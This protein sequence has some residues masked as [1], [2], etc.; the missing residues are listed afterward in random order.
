MEAQ[1][2]CAGALL[3][4]G[5]TKAREPLFLQQPSAHS[6][7]LLWPEGY[8]TEQSRRC[9]GEFMRTWKLTPE[10][11]Q[12]VKKVDYLDNVKCT[13]EAKARLLYKINIRGW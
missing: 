2:H 4:G 9:R 13:E 12:V 5:N 10:I 7:G 3:A 6:T 11:L 1:Q 8:L